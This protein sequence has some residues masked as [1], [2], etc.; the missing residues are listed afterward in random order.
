MMLHKNLERK[1]STLLDELACNCMTGK[2]LKLTNEVA[3][4]IKSTL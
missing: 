2:D 4:N 3:T 1:R